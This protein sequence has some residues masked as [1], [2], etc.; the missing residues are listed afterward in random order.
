MDKIQQGDLLFARCPV[1]AFARRI[2][3]SDRSFVLAKGETTG[4]AH[5]AD[6]ETCEIYE[7]QDRLYMRVPEQTVVRHQEHRPVVI[8]KGDYI[9]WQVTEADPY[10]RSKPKPR[11][12]R[13]PVCD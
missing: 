12:P 3:Q 4:H 5:T 7:L 1:P 9:I 8:E 2:V 6:L 11:R 10:E 13:G